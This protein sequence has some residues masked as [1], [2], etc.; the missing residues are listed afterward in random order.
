MFVVQSMYDTCN[1]F[2]T[3]HL[4]SS[5]Y[6][7]PVHVCGS[8]HVGYLQQLQHH[9]YDIDNALHQSMLLHILKSVLLWII[10]G[11]AYEYKPLNCTM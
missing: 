6:S 11:K 10:T 7:K 9:A 8:N 3:M 2:N 1:S 5:M 4:V